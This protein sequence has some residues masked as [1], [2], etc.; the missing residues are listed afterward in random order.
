LDSTFKVFDF[1]RIFVGDTPPLFLLEIIFRTLIMY[2]YTVIL[3]RI[4]GKRGMGQLSMLELAIIISFGS[5]VGDPMVGADIP[6]FHGL[7]AITTVT[8]FQISL[9]RLINRNKKVEAALE[10]KPNLVVSNGIIQWEC[11]KMDNISKEDLFRTLRAK[12]VK[13]LGQIEKAHFETSGQVSVLYYPEKKVKP[14]LSVSPEEEISEAIYQAGATL[15]E[16]G[17]YSCIDCGNTISLK[18]GTALPPCDNCK[19]ETWTKAVS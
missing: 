2:A 3:L 5:A 19:G 8:I 6:I 15:G 10:G 11:M 7:T 17:L 1:H 4:L 9:E 13:H 12:D 16:G 18:A 14:G